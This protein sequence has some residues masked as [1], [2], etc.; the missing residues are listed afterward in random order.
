M[1]YDKERIDKL[2][3]AP[4]SALSEIVREI[5]ASLGANSAI[6]EKLANN[7]DLLRRTAATMSEADMK[8]LL[9][10]IDEATGEKVLNALNKHN[11]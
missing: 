8:K 9:A 10:G 3:C 6:S 4:D 1:D 5:A 11:M 2:K 7:P